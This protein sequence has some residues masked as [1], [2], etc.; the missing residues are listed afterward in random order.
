MLII[1]PQELQT[2]RLVNQLAKTWQEHGLD[3]ETML[4]TLREVRSEYTP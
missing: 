1:T 4:K 2:D 3:L